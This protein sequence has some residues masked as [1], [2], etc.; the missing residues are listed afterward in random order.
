[1]SAKA[2]RGERNARIRRIHAERR[3]HGDRSEQ[4]SNRIE[5]REPRQHDRHRGNRQRHD[6]VVVLE[7]E[8]SAVRLESDPTSTATYGMSSAWP[9]EPRPNAAPTL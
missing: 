3:Q 5:R 9:K 1:M 4:K 6:D 8:Q 2:A 7:S